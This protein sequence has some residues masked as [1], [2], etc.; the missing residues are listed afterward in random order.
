MIPDDKT[1]LLKT[2]L[3]SLSGDIAARLAS[4]IE[5]DRLR[6]GQMLPHEAILEGLRPVLRDTNALRTPTPL[7]LFCRPFEDLFVS[8][9]RKAKQKASIAR[10]SLLPIWLWLCR[11]LMP[12]ETERYIAE[13]KALIVARKYTEATRRAEIFW[14]QAG[15]ALQAGLKGPT[16]RAALG[17]PLVV[18]DAQE[19][20]LLLL[21]G[22]DIMHIQETLPRPT[23]QFTEELVWQLRAIYDDLVTRMPDAA[24][25]VAVVAMNRLARPWEALRLPMQ[26]CRQHY[27]T[28]ISKTDM[29]LVGEILFARMEYLRD[30]ILATRHPLFNAETLLDQVAHFTELSS[31][32]VK[33]I[34]IKRDGEWG[35][36]L[37]KDRSQTGNVMDGFMDRAMR[38]IAAAMPMQKG[39]GGTA[40]FSRSLDHEKRELAIRYT[41]LVV[42]SRNFAAAGSFAAKQKTAYEDISAYLRRYIEDVVKELKSGDSARRAIAD[43]YFQLCADLTGLLFSDKDVELLQRRGRAAQSTAA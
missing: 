6:D 39:T 1:G 20:A 25:Y 15:A 30:A 43:G 14:G 21:A 19:M 16:A 9:A 40:D 22:T 33:E 29:G 2:F 23:P 38:E 18:A 24:P 8:S 31:A 26:I 35:Q 42:G 3:G 28:L 5:A 37:L 7:R 12:A 36:R 34:E 4:A 41:K 10:G 17:D 13:S 27:D 11:D 32:I